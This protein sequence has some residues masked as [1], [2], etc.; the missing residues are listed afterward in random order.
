M[1]ANLDRYLPDTTHRDYFR[2]ALSDQNPDQALFCR[3]IALDQLAHLTTA[4]LSD[5]GGNDDWP[6]LVNQALP[7]NLYQVFEVVSDNLSLGL[8]DV[9][10][11][12]DS[13]LRDLV[14]AFDTVAADDLCHP[15][16]RP[17]TELLAHLKAPTHQVSSFAQSLAERFHSTIAQKYAASVGNLDL[18]V[19]EHTVWSGLVA[20]IE[21]GRDVLAALA[22][23]H[24]EPAMRARTIERYEAVD[25]TLTT[26]RLSRDDL[27]LTSTQTILVTPTLGYF[28]TVFGEILGDDPGY[29]AALDDGSLLAAFDT[30]SLLVRLQN[31]IG[32][33]LLLMPRTERTA[34]LQHLRD[35][36]EPLD[37]AI[38]LL[39][40][41]VN[42]PVL[43]RFRK[44]LLN[45]E[46][47]ICLYEVYRSD[48]LRTGM[49][50]FANGLDFFADLYAR[51]KVAFGEQLT[52]LDGR[53]HDHRTT[54]MARRFVDFHEKMYTQAYDDYD[55]AGDY[56][57]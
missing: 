27:V 55:M 47:N 34:F 25:R 33:P 18:D 37:T 30:G 20:N 2:W 39:T 4:V 1:A 45:G 38:S 51:N 56:A 8:A 44:D 50:A 16:S 17:A 41:A 49:D 15:T 52:D 19:L 12:D 10:A 24:A 9:R 5:I 23:T 26:L 36:A 43:N 42:E 14:V 46:F 3:I 22:G 29:H 53:L 11:D 7:V 57:V 35:R 28:G 48:S 21:S 32:T 54:V 13:E 40:K 31:D 6:T